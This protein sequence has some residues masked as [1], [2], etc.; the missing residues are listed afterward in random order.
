MRF[1]ESNNSIVFDLSPEDEKDLQ[2]GVKTLDELYDEFVKDPLPKIEASKERGLNGLIG[3]VGKIDGSLDLS[4]GAGK[5][6]ILEGI[7]YAHYEKIVRQTA[8]T[9]KTGT[10][11]L[12]VVTSINGEYPKGL[13]ESYVEEFFE[14]R[15][16]IYR[17]KR[18]R[19]FTKTGK[20][21][22]PIIEFKCLTDEKSKEGHRSGDS[23]ESVE[24]VNVND[25]DIFVNSQMMGQNDAGKFLTGTDKVQKEMIVNLLKMDHAV[26]KCLK[27]TRDKKNSN[28]K[29]I[30]KFEYKVQASKKELEKI[31]TESFT[32]LFD[33]DD[34]SKTI[35]L[36]DNKIFE[37]SELVKTNE[38][39]IDKLDLE[40]N[41]LKGSE[42]IKEKEKIK[43]EG[44]SLKED[45]SN[46]SE[47]KAKEVKNW[48]ELK[49]SVSKTISSNERESSRLINLLES[50]NKDLTKME[51]DFA[52]NEFDE[53]KKELLTKIKLKA[54]KAKYVEKEIEDNS[55]VLRE[56]K[57]KLVQ[58]IGEKEGVLNFLKAQ[59]K[60]INTKI[61][62][63]P[64]GELFKCPECDSD[65]PKKHFQEKLDKYRKDFKE[66]EAEIEKLK[67]QKSIIISKQEDNQEKISK[68]SKIYSKVVELE[69]L[70]I[71][72]KSLETSLEDTRRSIKETKESMENSRVS[73]EDSKIQ[74]KKAEEQ[75]VGVNKKYED[76]ELSINEKLKSLKEKYNELDQETKTI[77]S[78][79]D[80]LESLRSS[81]QNSN[82]QLNN[83]IGSLEEKKKR[84]ESLIEDLTS[85][86]EEYSTLQI[87]KDRYSKLEKYFGLEG[88]QTR[89]VKKYLPLLNVYAKEF[90]D[91]LSDGKMEVVFSI[92]SSSKVDCVIKGGTAGSFNMLSGGEQMIVRLAVDIGLSLLSFSRSS[93]KPEM[94]CLD[95]IFGPLDAS[96][97][98]AVFKM[99]DV[100]RDKFKRVL[101]I[102][103]NP[104]IQSMVEKNIVVEKDSNMHGLSRIAMIE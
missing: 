22:S 44:K 58:E 12:S 42:K 60:K 70:E 96:K 15:G 25:Y 33:S 86:N 35:S 61:S 66:K 83:E 18:G 10:A 67:E 4:N 3:I 26:E 100:L 99:L 93:Q 73:L 101:L 55:K 78:K 65:V 16:K 90:L 63:M 14:E 72:S 45:L 80:E 94:I 31:H 50:K 6:T 91:I 85:Q 89:I 27:I 28:L 84:Y 69:S 41:Q 37:N 40:I 29:E 87:K 64:D 104:E 32:E 68:I 95:E 59:G 102:S 47:D 39:A 76:K 88:V 82:K 17:V 1:G 2:N 5:S 7:C 77:Q 74:L 52:E 98:K 79:I 23:K 19:T 43:E 20:S 30:E 62:E 49:V 34:L 24:E 21:K 57:E 53:E 92:N 103:H 36:F 38:K 71:R 81:N 48:D 8:N 46:L 56:E 11:G 54:E 75:I 51:K 97:S 13:T 9:D